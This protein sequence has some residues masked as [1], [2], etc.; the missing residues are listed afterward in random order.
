MHTNLTT[1]YEYTADIGRVLQGSMLFCSINT[2]SYKHK[3]RTTQETHYRPA[4]LSHCD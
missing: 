1:V 4:M 2:T 3:A